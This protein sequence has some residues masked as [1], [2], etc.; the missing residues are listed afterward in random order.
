MNT[1]HRLPPS[2][3]G[4][5]DRKFRVSN[6][7]AATDTL[8]SKL[9]NGGSM[10]NILRS[11]YPE[12]IDRI[13]HDIQ[14][15]NENISPLERRFL[16]KSTDESILLPTKEWIHKKIILAIDYLLYGDGDPTVLFYDFLDISD[17]QITETIEKYYSDYSTILDPKKIIIGIRSIR[18]GEQTRESFLKNI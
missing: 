5:K 1:T 17:I 15:T 9:K 10:G 12:E 2:G 11:F 16:L 14:A 13:L 4:E 8:I 3:I 18:N 6:V 7:D